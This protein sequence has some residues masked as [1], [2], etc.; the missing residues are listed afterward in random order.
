MALGA[1]LGDD[2]DAPAAEEAPVHWRLTSPCRAGSGACRPVSSRWSRHVEAPAR[3]RPP[4]APDRHR[5]RPRTAPQLQRRLEA[6][7]A[8]RLARGR[9][10]A[11]GRL[12]RRR[13]RCRP[14]PPARLAERNRLGA[15]ARAGGRGAPRRRGRARRRR[16]RSRRS[17]WRAAQAEEQRLRQLWREA[18]GKLAQTRDVLTAIERAGARDGEQARR[19]VRCTGAR[20]GRAR[21]RA[22]TCWPRP[23]RPLQALAG[24][25]DLEADLAAAKTEPPTLRSRVSEAPHRAHHARAR[26]PR[27]R[28]AAGGHRRRARALDDALGRRRAADRHA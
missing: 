11:L 25:E 22:R 18:Q 12:R 9:P 14:P 1:A 26:A 24:T 3:A 7:P 17:A 27:P 10:V 8:A 20:R 2:L 5:R 15:L 21:R 28:R 4:P 16:A 19:R 13:R 6:R 23:R